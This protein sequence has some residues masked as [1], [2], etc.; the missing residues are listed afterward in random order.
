MV[1]NIH[2]VAE[3]FCLASKSAVVLSCQQI[4]G[5]VFWVA[6]VLISFLPPGVF[7]T[8]ER[9]FH[10]LII[11]QQQIR[12]ATVILKHYDWYK[13]STCVSLG[14]RT[15]QL[16]RRF[17]RVVT[18]S[19]KAKR[20]V[21]ELQCDDYVLFVVRRDQVIQENWGIKGRVYALKEC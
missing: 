8:S 17:R 1:D 6:A 9:V 3:F 11:G 2:N 20:T 16:N 12:S 13:T 14:K 5:G 7:E 18:P 21:S 10:W 15:R 19:Q 4:C